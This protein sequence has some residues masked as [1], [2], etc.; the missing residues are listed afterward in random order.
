MKAHEL[1]AMTA[2][3]LRDHTRDLREE[4]FNLRFRRVSQN[5]DNP[6]RLRVARREL[7]RALTVL[8]EKESSSSPPTPEKPEGSSE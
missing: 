4:I 6:L 2:E 3:E 7:A 5:L 8:R 1:R